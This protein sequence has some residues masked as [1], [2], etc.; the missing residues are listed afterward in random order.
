MLSR[1]LNVEVSKLHIW[2]RLTAPRVSRWGGGQ[3]QALPAT[4]LSHTHTAPTEGTPT[5][6]SWT[7]RKARCRSALSL[8]NTWQATSPLKCSSASSVVKSAIWKE[9]G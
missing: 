1:A 4:L 2:L 7:S 6:S 8:S 3:A 9:E 5:F